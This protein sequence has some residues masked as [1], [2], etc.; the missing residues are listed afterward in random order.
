MQSG[1]GV[2]RETA[3]ARAGNLDLIY[4]VLGAREK[5]KLQK[6]ERANNLAS[7]HFFFFFKQTNKKPSLPSSLVTPESLWRFFYPR[8][9]MVWLRFS[10]YGRETSV[11]IESHL[12]EPLH[13]K[14][15]EEVK[16]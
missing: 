15:R 10:V 1:P 8:N 5:E 9:S 6:E 13:K 16:A 7:N 14:I 12:V 11:V 2:N 4:A 3:F